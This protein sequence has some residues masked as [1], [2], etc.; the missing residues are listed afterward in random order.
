M[1]SSQLNHHFFV[2]A[3]ARALE[4]VGVNNVPLALL[5]LYE[6]FLSGY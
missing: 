1:G 2:P 6:P 3:L 5:K 4:V